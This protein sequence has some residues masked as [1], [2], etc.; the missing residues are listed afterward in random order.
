LTGRWLVTGAAGFIGS[1]VC[2]EL[3]KD[4]R[5]VVGVDSF[6]S[7]YDPSLKEARVARLTAFGNFTL[8]RLDLADE[9]GTRSVFAGH[10]PEVVVHLAAQPGISY[11]VTNPMAY[12]QS[13]LVG[14]LSVLESCRQVGVGHLLYASSS[15]VYGKNSR[16][17]F[18]VHDPADHPV[19]L[20]A[21]TKR[22]NELMAHSYSHLFG[23]PTTGL[24]FFS[25]YGPW[26]RPDMAYYSFASKMLRGEPITIYGDGTQLRDFTYIDDIV[27]GLIKLADRPPGANPDWDPEHPD[28]ATSRAPYRVFNIGHGEQVSV[29]RLIDLLESL[30]GIRADRRYEPARPADMPATHAD[31]SDLSAAIGFVPHTGLESGIKAFVEWFLHYHDRPPGSFD[32]PRADGRPAAGRRSETVSGPKPSAGRGRGAPAGTSSVGPPGE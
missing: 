8:A 31:V 25:V 20:Y 30:L 9:P 10:R 22:S 4:G 3:L 2:L 29:N 32:P 7:Y 24:R 28:P 11:S 17:P 14:T 1:A 19:S 21:A 23:L 6:N 12:A 15:S 18:S 13:N 26:G 5:E 27:A 16:M